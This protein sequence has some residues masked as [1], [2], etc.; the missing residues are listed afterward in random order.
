MMALV[1]KRKTICG[2]MVYIL[3]NDSRNVSESYN[4]KQTNN[5]MNYWR[6]SIIIDYFKY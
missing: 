6:L 3:R 5:I 4:G 2:D 1:S